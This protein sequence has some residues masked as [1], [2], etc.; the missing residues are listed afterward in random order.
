MVASIAS[1]IIPC[2]EVLDVGQGQETTFMSPLK[3]DVIPGIGRFRRKILLEELN[4]TL[5]RE[6]AALD[7]GN[8]RL[9]FGSQA[10]VIH[11]RALGIDPTPV[12]PPAMK[13]TINE[14]ITFDG[15]END[16]LVLLGG[17]YRLVEKC[18]HRLRERALV[19]RSAGLMIRYADQEEAVRR[20]RFPF[21]SFWNMDLYSPL[22]RIFF[23]I[24]RRRV[25]VRFMR[26][27]F[28]DLVPMPAQFSLFPKM[29][30]E[31]EKEVLVTRAL[32]HIREKY[33]DASITY[34]RAA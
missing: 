29:S 16:D 28:Q 1:H 30:S 10:F 31:E 33:G 18:S 34:A 25:R 9:I 4:I 26:V 6:L 27:W 19:P 13:P 5:V 12:Y 22:E 2:E 20:V 17:L 14:E 11:Q 24:C 21:E 23:K 15:D 7:M 3:V 32:D 8:L